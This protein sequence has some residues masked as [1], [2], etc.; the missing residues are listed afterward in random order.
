MNI[1]KCHF[2]PVSNLYDNHKNR[3]SKTRGY[4]YKFGLAPM[5]F[6]VLKRKLLYLYQY[7]KITKK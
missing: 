2:G 1:I 4:G 5:N 6:L 3:E 7:L